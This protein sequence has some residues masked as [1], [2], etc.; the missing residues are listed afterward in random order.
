MYSEHF[1]LHENPFTPISTAS[2]PFRSKELEEAL[3]HFQYARLN[4]ESFFLLVG[5][6]GAGKTTAVRAIVE[7]LGSDL[8]VA[9]LSHTRLDS[10]EL[11]EEVLRRFGL[12]SRGPSSKSQLIG[13]LESHLASSAET[14]PAVLVI[15]EAHLLSNAALEEVRLLSNLER[16]DRPL[17]Q[18]CLVGQPE[19]LDRLRQH[20]LRPL[21]QRIAVRYVFGRLTRA[22][23]REYIRHRLE[24]AGAADPAAVFCDDAAD[25]VHEMAE[26]LPRE[27]NVLAGQAML[28]AYVENSPVVKRR[29][30]RTTKH[31]Y[32]FEGVRVERPAFAQATPRVDEEKRE[33]RFGE[34]RVAEP[35]LEPPFKPDVELD[36]EPDEDDRSDLILQDEELSLLETQSSFSS[37][38]TVALTIAAIAAGILA[39]LALVFFVYPSGDSS[40]VETIPEPPPPASSSSR[41]NLPQPEIVLPVAVPA[42]LP[43]TTSA[44]PE[45]EL[46]ETAAVDVPPPPPPSLPPIS[47]PPVSTAAAAAD[48]LELGAWLARNGS[49]DEAIAAFREALALDPGYGDA[50]YN[51]GVSLL[52]KGQLG[53]AIEALR[54]AISISP[55]HGLAQR[56]LGIAL[57]QSGELIDAAVSLQRAVELLPNDVFALRYLASVLR[58]SGELEQAIDA[59]GRAIALKPDDAAL[60]QELG[61]ALR[62]AGRLPEA[63]AALQRSIDIDG[64]LA[65][66]HYTLG[67]TLLEMGNRDAGER[68]IAEARR[69]GYDP[70]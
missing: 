32:G 13:R 59:T 57:R 45:L 19:L 67:V 6:V 8:P 62:A 53:E 27:I 70:R 10:R 60:Q 33:P 40:N 1:G 21:R 7:S 37:G 65:L 66:S 43:S 69:L 4:R 35:R 68:E 61:F 16:F 31:D 22:E 20:R 5:E 52:E 14:S 56:A 39:T 64:N 42:P 49:L 44:P 51:L 29:H 46:E 58:E 63:T 36:V 30:V 34:P 3:S 26:G 47:P 23:T 2:R 54:K 55:D 9:V 48:R 11:L 12:D 38:R 25:G 28:N 50:F 41:R 17:L 18:I 24:T 15:D